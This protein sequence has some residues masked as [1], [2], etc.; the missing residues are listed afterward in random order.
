MGRFTNAE[1]QAQRAAHFPPDR[2]CFAQNS[3]AA[4]EDAASMK[5]YV[6]GEIT[7]TMLCRCFE[8]NNYLPKVTEAQALNELKITG[9][10]R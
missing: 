6:D 7:L 3:T 4:L 8:R 2:I 10:I 1:R 5:A 9:W